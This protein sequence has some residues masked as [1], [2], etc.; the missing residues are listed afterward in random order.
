MAL[1]PAWCSFPAELFFSSSVSVPPLY[2]TQSCSQ[3][4]AIS[5]FTHLLQPLSSVIGSILCRSQSLSLFFLLPSLP[6]LL[7]KL[8]LCLSLSCSSTLCSSSYCVCIIYLYTCI[9][10]CDLFTCMYLLR[11]SCMHHVTHTIM[12]YI[13]PFSEGLPDC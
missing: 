5:F 13:P 8:F 6:L 10:S 11:N 9:S 7:F 3:L 4:T 12:K 2:S 1:E